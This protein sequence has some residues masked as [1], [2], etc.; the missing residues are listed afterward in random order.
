PTGLTFNTAYYATAG[1]CQITSK[2]SAAPAATAIKAFDLDDK[3]VWSD[4]SATS[5]LQC[6]YVDGR[7]YLVTSYAV[8]CSDQQR[9]PRSL[10]LCGSNDGGITWA[11]LDIRKTPEFSGQTR[12]REF[13]IAKPAKWNIYRLNVTAAHEPEGIAIAT[14]ELNEAIHC[15][16]KAAVATVSL[17][18]QSLNLAVNAR[19][20]L[21]A[22][23]APMETFE[24]EVAWWSSDPA[25]AEVRKVGE[26]IAIVVGKKPGACNI[27]AMIDK[28]QQTCAVTVVPSTLP[29]GWR[30]DELNA[31]MIPGAISVAGGTFTL[32][33]CGHAMT[34]FWERVRDQGTFV[35][36]PVTGDAAISARLTSLAP[37][38]GGPSYQWD[39]RPPSVAGLMIR[40]SLT[41]KCG[42]YRLIQVEASG[43]LVCRWRNKSGDQDDNQKKD[44]GK[45]TL[46]LHLRLIQTGG[47]TQVFT[48]TDGRDWGEPRM[49]LP[50]TFD[51]Q[52]RIGLFVCSGNTF[53]S[54]TSVFD[55]VNGV[56]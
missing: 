20:T 11:S 33:G 51:E 50:T 45:V 32:T 2:G 10:E 48:S 30:Y 14:L 43:S 25:V 56:K 18:H 42:R 1:M 36:Q 41:E 3:T 15:R 52:S 16:P 22:T 7:K 26:Q 6:Q 24:R 5:W 37:D 34:A 13:T 29:A 19:A 44:F 54:T 23:L 38:V 40:E 31:P 55:S 47:Q 4:K 46:P 9:M 21:N 49:I 39:N 53:S 35:S 27:S 28:V 12:R 17:D 8:V